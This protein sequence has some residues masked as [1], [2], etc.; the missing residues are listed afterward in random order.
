MNKYYRAIYKSP[1]GNLPLISNADALIALLWENDLATRVKIPDALVDEDND[2][3]LE[4]KKQLDEYFAGSRKIFNIPL[5][6]NGTNFQKM[7]WK[8][9][10]SI[11][12]GDTRS[13]GE[14][15][16]R[17]H[18]P[19]ASRAVGAANGKNP[20]SIIVP[21]HRVIGTNGKLTGF[22]GGIDVKKKL[23]ELESAEHISLFNQ[24]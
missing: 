11:P 14:L 24:K 13:Y 17:I 22:A 4:T 10:Q 3:L 21:C 6:M 18:Q 9:L 15:A 12:Y 19:T 7:I 2:I 16:K 8:E 1:V 5:C 23:L 20:I